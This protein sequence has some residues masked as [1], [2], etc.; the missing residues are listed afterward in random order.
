MI[1]RWWCS[2]VRA[3][4]LY[5]ILTLLL[6]SCSFPSSLVFTSFIVVVCFLT[7]SHLPIVIDIY[8]NWQEMDQTFLAAP[9]GDGI[10]SVCFSPTQTE[11]L[12]VTSWDGTMRLYDAIRNT[13]RSTFNFN[14]ACLTGCFNY[15]GSGAFVGGLDA[16]VR[17]LDFSR[18]S[19]TDL[20]CHSKAV[21]CMECTKSGILWV[22][23]NLKY[24]V[25][26]VMYLLYMSDLLVVGMVVSSHGILE[27]VPEAKLKLWL[28]TTKF[29]AFQRLIIDWL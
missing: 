21:S 28:R 15:E 8:K 20:G 24:G 14:G 7:N 1:P 23:I 26:G 16:R 3:F 9:P 13:P 10:S 11:L 27:E 25:Y 18:G 29:S 5:G 19:I 4:L 12:L 2:C 22:T 6:H 17:M